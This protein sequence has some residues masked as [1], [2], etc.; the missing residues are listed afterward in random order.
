LLA[1]DIVD[2]N[3]GGVEHRAGRKG[4]ARGKRLVH[5]VDALVFA[6]DE[7]EL[8]GLSRAGGREGAR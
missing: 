8:E 3:V 7:G 4:N 2:A 1:R 6:E 5:A